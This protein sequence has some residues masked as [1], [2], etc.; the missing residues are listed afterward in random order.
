MDIRNNVF[1]SIFLGTINSSDVLYIKIPIINVIIDIRENKIKS[2][3]DLVICAHARV[4]D[5]INKKKI[6]EPA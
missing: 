2:W 3:L 6:K 4:I 5:E 1:F